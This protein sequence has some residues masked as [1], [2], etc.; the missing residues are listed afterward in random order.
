MPKMSIMLDN[1]NKSAL[2]YTKKKVIELKWSKEA[3]AH[4]EKHITYPLTGDDILDCCEKMLD[5]GNIERK[6]FYLKIRYS[7]TYRSA[8]DVYNDLER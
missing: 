3:V 1:F 7:K 2:S 5:I 8:K 6:I 4:L